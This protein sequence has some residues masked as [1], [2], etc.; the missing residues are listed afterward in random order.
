MDIIRNS[1]T[2]AAPADTVFAFLA[3]PETASL[4]MP[5]HL[6]DRYQAHESLVAGDTRE[7]VYDC[8]GIQWHE[9]RWV[10]RVDPDQRRVIWHTDSR[11]NLREEW[12]VEALDA[13]RS[14][15][16]LERQLAPMTFGE[17]MVWNLFISIL[18]NQAMNCR[19]RMTRK[20]LEGGWRGQRLRTA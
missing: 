15:L 2:I 13:G 1:I 14:R 10:V 18:M 9:R 7:T 11:F 8:M 5:P 3:D 16:V 4:R 6:H 12:R 17:S 20:N 19:L